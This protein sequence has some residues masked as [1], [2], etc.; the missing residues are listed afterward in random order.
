M[1]RS[2][3]EVIYDFT[4][5]YGNEERN[6]AEDFAGSWTALQDFIKDL[7][8]SGC[9]NITASCIREGDD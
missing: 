6:I 4:D 3:Y 9:Y 2:I 7:K 5:R 8:E 1:A